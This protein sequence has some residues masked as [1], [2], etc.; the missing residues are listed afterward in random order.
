MKQIENYSITYT[1]KKDGS[2]FWRAF[3]HLSG[4]QNSYLGGIYFYDEE[5]G[6]AFL[7]S[8]QRKPRIFPRMV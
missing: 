7:K 3:I 2:T 4:A 1:G 8:R 5:A 6:G